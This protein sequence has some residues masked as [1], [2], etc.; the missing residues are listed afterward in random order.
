MTIFIDIESSIGKSSTV[1]LGTNDF[2]PVWLAASARVY[3]E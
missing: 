1:T 3:G 2:C